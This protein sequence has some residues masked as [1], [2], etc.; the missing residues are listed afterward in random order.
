MGRKIR[1]N[2]AVHKN[3]CSDGGVRQWIVTRQLLVPALT[4][5]DDPFVLQRL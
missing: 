2:D 4:P 1:V 5:I 3:V